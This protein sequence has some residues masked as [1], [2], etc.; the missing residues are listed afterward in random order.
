MISIQLLPSSS[1]RWPL[2]TIAP[3]PVYQE[4]SSNTSPPLEDNLTFVVFW[5]NQEVVHKLHILICCSSRDLGRGTLAKESRG[6]KQYFHLRKL[7]ADASCS[8]TVLLVRLLGGV[9]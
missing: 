5:S 4:A 6:S 1:L 7:H 9:Q 3:P 8:K 2:R